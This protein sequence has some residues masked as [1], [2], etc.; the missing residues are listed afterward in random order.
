MTSAA[1]AGTAVAAGL[2]AAAQSLQVLRVVGLPIDGWKSVY[3]ASKSGLFK[4]YGLDVQ[5]SILPS[6]AAAAAALSGGSVDIAYTNTLTAV[7]AYSH[8]IPMQYVATGNFLLPGKSPTLMLVL[9]DSPIK[10]G[11][12]LNGKVLGSGSLRDLNAVA[13]FAWI[14]KTG[15]DSTTV[16]GIEVPPSAGAAYLEQHRADAVTLNEPTA[17]LALAAG[18]VRVLAQPY[19]AMSGGMASGLV[20]LTPVI[21][22]KADAMTRFAK[23]MHEASTWTNAHQA[24]TVPMVAE[25]TGTDAAVIAKGARFTDADYLEP[26]YLQPLIDVIAKYKLIDQSFPA[27]ELISSVAVKP[28]SR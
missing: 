1:F 10:T 11:R 5:S 21:E 25:Y 14:E 6:G 3:Y 7:Q 15:G 12:D 18:T 26:R 27:Q 24:E 17:S 23:A 8:K 28:P 4:K 19:D 13:S 2:P 9:K 20:A 16:K 22:A